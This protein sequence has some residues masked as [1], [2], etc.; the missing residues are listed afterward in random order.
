MKILA[1]AP[2]PFFTPR[3]T[4][5][6]VYYRTLVTA[7]MNVEVDLL[8][9]GEGQDIEI[10][11]VRIIRIPHFRFL[12]NVKIGPSLF[13]LFLDVFIMFWTIGLLLK[14]RYKVV[15]AHEEAVF[16]CY[17][18]K[19]LFNFKLIYDM[20]SSLP[21]Q[22]INFK[23]T[24]S[25]LLIKLFAILENACL[26][27]AEATITICP[28]LYNYAK[29]IVRDR[30]L[31][32]LIENSIFDPVKFKNNKHQQIFQ[33]LAQKR[34]V[35]YA[36]TLEPYQGIDILLRAFPLVLQQQPDLFLLIV[37]GTPEQVKYYFDLAQQLGISIHCAFTG[38]ISPNAAK[39]YISKA[40]VQISSRISGQNTPLKV[41]EQLSNG[42]PIVATNIYSHTQVLNE[43][44]AFLVEPK[45]ESMAEGI[46]AALAPSCDSKLKA[47][48]AKQ[49]Y[50]QKYSRTIYKEKLQQVIETVVNSSLKDQ[51]Y[52]KNI[53]SDK[54]QATINYKS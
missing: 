11:G 13:K 34:L 39:D 8:T 42:I 35:I 21:E 46:L 36:G 54:Y 50:E 19:P 47:A 7:E 41:Y 20:H 49:L 38:R 14:H 48:R 22:L 15:H 10:P 32:V 4:P 1:I 12:G 26:Q 5:L 40:A 25:K 44:V 33:S 9:Y 53:E 18:L 6:S 17:F 31:L 45:P 23:F 30:N 2:Q 37:G 24:K 3:G 52:S 28:S 43:D 16:I 29:T 51:N 27:A